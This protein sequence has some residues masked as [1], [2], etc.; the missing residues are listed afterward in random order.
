MCSITRSPPSSKRSNSSTDNGMSLICGDL[1]GGS[2]NIMSNDFG[3][4][5]GK[6]RRKSPQITSPSNFS[7]L[8]LSSTAL[9][10][11]RFSSIEIKDPAPLLNASIPTRPVPAQISRKRAPCIRKARILKSAC[12]TFAPVGRTSPPIGLSTLLPLAVPPVMRKFSC[13]PSKKTPTYNLV[14]RHEEPVHTIIS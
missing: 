5:T 3:S 1:Y 12:L 7:F 14:L 6:T 11:A 10:R 8:R 13:F 9:E 4:S 2:A